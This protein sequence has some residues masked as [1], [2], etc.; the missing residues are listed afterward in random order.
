M[1]KL[2]LCTFLL[3]SILLQSQKLSKEA[4]DYKDLVMKYAN[5]YLTSIQKDVLKNNYCGPECYKTYVGGEFVPWNKVVSDLEV[6][7]NIGSIV[8]ESTHHLNHQDI[9]VVSET[10]TMSINKTPVFKSNIMVKDMIKMNKNVVDMFRFDNYVNTD[11]NMSSSVSGIYGLMNEYCAYYN[12]TLASL[13]LYERFKYTSSDIEEEEQVLRKIEK[14][15]AMSA[16]GSSTAFYEF[17]AFIGAY[18]IYAKKNR[19]DVYQGILDN[20][21]LISAYSIVTANYYEIVQKIHKLFPEHNFKIQRI[22]DSGSSTIT[23]GNNEILL[24]SQE[25]YNDYVNELNDFINK[26][27]IILTRK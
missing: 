16:M 12:G 17:N 25:I 3:S 11:R 18:L 5:Y 14:E 13:I 22:W 6:L 7:E 27:N 23:Y 19:H 20:Q 21:S 4:Q 9:Y 8:H 2:I 15:L 1:K 26:D 10:A 24:L